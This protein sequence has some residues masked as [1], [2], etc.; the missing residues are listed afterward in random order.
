MHY[1][2][3]GSKDGNENQLP[4]TICNYYWVITFIRQKAR[5]R[6]RRPMLSFSLIGSESLPKFIHKSKH[7]REDFRSK[8]PVYF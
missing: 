7:S 3:S 6:D 1:W 8:I 4:I 5:K 2:L